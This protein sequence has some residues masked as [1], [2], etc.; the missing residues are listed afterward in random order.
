M[1]LDSIV[2]AVLVA[3][4]LGLLVSARWW[5]VR[6]ADLPM[7]LERA[8]SAGVALAAGLLITDAP[9]WLSVIL[10]GPAAAGMLA[11][12]VARGI[13]DAT[14]R[15]VIEHEGG[16]A[17]TSRWAGLPQTLTAIC[18]LVSGG[19]VLVG[20]SDGPGWWAVAMVAAALLPLVGAAVVR[21]CRDLQQ[22]AATSGYEHELTFWAWELTE[23]RLLA[24][25]V[26]LENARLARV[27]GLAP[28]LRVVPEPWQPVHRHNP[29]DEARIDGR[30]Q[31]TDQH[32]PR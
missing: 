2:V 29:G 14:H 18:L 25:E 10:L 7:M 11:A 4:T 27:L 1:M 19:V 6:R 28:F 21:V 9:T 24:L 5:G 32:P 31:P 20:W 22:R 8:G 23:D 3:G 15:R 30:P 16:P 12:G 13:E 17:S 26:R